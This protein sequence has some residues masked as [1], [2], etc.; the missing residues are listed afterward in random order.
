MTRCDGCDKFTDPDFVYMLYLNINI[1]DFQNNRTIKNYIENYC[2]RCS[3]I[4]FFPNCPPQ[5]ER[6]WSNTNPFT[7]NLNVLQAEWRIKD[8]LV[9]RFDLKRL[10]DQDAKDQLDYEQKHNKLC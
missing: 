6:A 7:D 4:R 5:L 9:S 1:V 10:K 2:Y 8:V 3:L